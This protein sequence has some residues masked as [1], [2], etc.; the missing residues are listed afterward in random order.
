MKFPVFD[1]HCDTPLNI[2]RGR[3]NHI[4]PPRMK[5]QGYLGA[6]FA[7]FIPPASKTPFL[8]T[9]K[10]LMRTRRF[11]VD[12]PEYRILTDFSK[13]AADRLNVVLGV[14]GGHI[15]D[16]DFKQVEVLYDLGARVFTIVWNNSNRLAHSALAADKKGLTS[17][18]RQFIREMGRY[19]ILI[20]VSHAATRTVLD[21][22][23]ITGNKVFAS[24]SC[25]RRVNP[26]LRN[27]DDPAIRALTARGGIVG[28]NFSRKH[29][30]GRPVLDHIDYLKDNFGPGRAALGSDFDGIDDPVFNGP[31]AVQNLAGEMA[32]R[33]YRPSD[34][35]A[36]FSGNF[37][38]FLKRP[39][40]Q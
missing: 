12:D 6:V 25:V 24:H 20:D 18:G 8:D 26:F 7:H 14:E 37:I 22:C 23:D 11:L 27:I 5:S 35:T 13:I 28:V 10:M 30:G 33:G 4:D 16:R 19:E 31:A 39:L 29:L 1:L 32:E 2:Y 40:I 15:F 21:I 3:F 38:D 9:V 34:I 17:R 36:I